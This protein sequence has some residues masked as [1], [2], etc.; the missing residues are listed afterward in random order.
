MH[1]TFSAIFHQSRDNFYRFIPLAQKVASHQRSRQKITLILASR[2]PAF[3]IDGRTRAS[4]DCLTTI[5]RL[6]LIF[7]TSCLMP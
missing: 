7:Q 1:L 5:I 6:K 4:S 2:Q 3:V